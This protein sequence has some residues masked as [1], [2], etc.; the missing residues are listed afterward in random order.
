MQFPNN[1]ATGL[2]EKIVYQCFS[3][4]YSKVIVML[5]TATR[6]KVFYRIYNILTNEISI[7]NTVCPD[8]GEIMTK[9]FIECDN[10]SGFYCAW[11]CNCHNNLNRK[12]RRRIHV[13]MKNKG[14]L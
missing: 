1:K 10:G 6:N 12:D 5:D 14:K 9:S 3:P 11:L 2:T 7:I 4:D 13:E 8:C